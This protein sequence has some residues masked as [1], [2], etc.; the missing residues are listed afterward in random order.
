MGDVSIGSLLEKNK[1]GSLDDSKLKNY[2]EQIQQAIYW[3]SKPNYQTVCEI[4]NGMS[5]QDVLDEIWRIKAT[6]HLNPLA[7]FVPEAT[8]VNN[9]RL[10]AAI[11]ALQDA[12]PPDINVLIK[13]LPV[14]QQRAVKNVRAATQAPAALNPLLQPDFY[15]RVRLLPKYE[16]PPAPS[17]ATADGD[18]GKSDDDDDDEAHAAADFATAI[19]A[20]AP[21]GANPMT[22]SLTLIYRNFD[23]KKFGSK[24]TE[25]SIG[26]E[27]NVTVQLSPDPNNR[28]AYQAAI[29]LVNLHLKRHWGLFRPDVEFSVSG[30]AGAQAPGPTPTGAVQAQIEVHATTKISVT[31][32]TSLGFG[33]GRKPDDPP[34]RGAIHLGNRDVDMAFTP[35]MIGILGHWDPPS[36]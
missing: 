11:G 3:S 30:Q 22:Y 2:H 28:A 12:A 25:V 7:R 35:F 13:K 26:H 23:V 24:N 4:L 9:D 36:R 34:D 31:L 1:M 20:N 16:P 15:W 14:D 33:P 29:T 21:P 6:G 27:P 8:G 32:G 18:A 5:M 19:T 10:R 17:D